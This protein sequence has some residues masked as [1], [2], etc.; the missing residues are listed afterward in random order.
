MSPNALWYKIFLFNLD[1]FEQPFIFVSSKVSFAKLGCEEFSYKTVSQ[2]VETAICKC[3]SEAVAQRCS[4]KKVFLIEILQ[5]L[6]E[7]TCARVSLLMK[8]QA[9]VATL[10]KKR[11]RCRCFLWIFWNFEEHLFLQNSSGGYF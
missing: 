2:N 7:N 5:N 3:S 8:L 6:Q 9:K 4:V 1:W 10:F 11:P